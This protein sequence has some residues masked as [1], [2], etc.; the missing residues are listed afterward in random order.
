MFQ[1]PKWP[2]R[3]SSRSPIFNTLG[4][5]TEIHNWSKL[6]KALQTYRA[7]DRRTD[8]GDDNNPS[9]ERLRPRGKKPLTLSIDPIFNSVRKVPKIHFLCE[10][11]DS[12]WNPCW[13]IV[14]TSLDLH[15]RQSDGRTQATTI[16]F[17]KI[18][19]GVKI[20]TS[21]SLCPKWPCLI[22]LKVKVNPLHLLKDSRGF[23]NTHSVQKW[24]F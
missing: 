23:H 18:C 5:H 8:A 15:Y 14:R 17:D 7:T 20:E 1:R 4:K 10:F 24:R 16:P 21:N 12:S 6:V 2:W 22:M 11:V 13:V 9:A 3:W 19:R